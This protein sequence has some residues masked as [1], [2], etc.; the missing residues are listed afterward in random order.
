MLIEIYYSHLAIA[1][2]SKGVTMWCVV[3]AD[4]SI[5]CVISGFPLKNLGILNIDRCNLYHGSGEG[6][7]SFFF[8]FVISVCSVMCRQSNEA[9]MIT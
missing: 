9:G 5:Y 6:Q 7:Y 8:F 1:T 3:A 4:L 2:L